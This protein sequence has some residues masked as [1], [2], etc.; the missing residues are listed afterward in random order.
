MTEFVSDDNDQL[1][2]P[3]CKSSMIQVGSERITP[4]SGSSGS[5]DYVTSYTQDEKYSKFNFDWIEFQCTNC[6][7]KAKEKRIRES[8][9]PED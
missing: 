7:Y 5:A 1:F 2:C 6:G 3:M 8:S 4:G 9:T